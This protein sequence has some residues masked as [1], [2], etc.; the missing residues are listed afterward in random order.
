M[1]RWS[2]E[3]VAASPP[4][5]TNRR[6]FRVSTRETPRRDGEC[7]KRAAATRMDCF[8]AALRATTSFL[9]TAAGA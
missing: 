9:T 3:G 1:R 5:E 2:G 4:T 6:D 8:G 7:A